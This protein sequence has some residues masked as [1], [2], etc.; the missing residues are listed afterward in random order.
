MAETVL[1]PDVAAEPSEP[2]GDLH[3][4]LS[5]LGEVHRDGAYTLRWA[6]RSYPL[7]RHT[8]ETLRQAALDGATPPT[9]LAR[10]VRRTPGVVGLLQVLGPPDANGF[11]TLAFIAIAAPGKSAFTI[12]DLAQALVFLNPSVTVLTPSTADTVLKHIAG[13]DDLPGMT[14]A[15]QTSQ[16]TW[17]VPKPLVDASGQPVR[18][19]DGTQ[20]HTYELDP[21]VENS[22]TPVSGQSTTAIYSDATLSGARWKL[23]PGVAHLDMA[24]PAVSGGLAAANGSGYRISLL[25]GGPNFGVSVTVNGLSDDF[26]LDLTVTNS[27]VRHL[28]VFVSFLE[29]DG[30]TAIV[31][32]DNIWTQLMKG[33]M[34]PIVQAWLNLFDTEV[35]E[36]L[37]KMLES[38]DNT[39]KFC[40]TVGAEGTFLGIPV[41]TTSKNFTFALPSDVP[42]GT[43]RLMV[44]SLGTS[45]GLD[46]DPTAAWLG[47]SMTALIDLVVPTYALLSTAGEE[48]DTLFE[49]IF[50]SVPFLGAT[51][52][53]VFTVAKDIFDDPANTG[54]DLKA[55]LTSFADS[56]VSKVLTSSDVAAALAVYFGAEE[57]EEAIPYVGWALK[58]LAMGAA[59]AQLGQTIGEVIASPR[60]IEFDLKVTMDAVITLRPDTS[61]G[62]GSEFPATATSVHLTAQ[63]S[64]NTTRTYQ[65]AFDPAKG[66][67]LRIDWHD[68]PVGGHVTFV[69]A[70]FSAEGW[71]V[72]KGQ[73]ATIVNE[74]TKGQ[75]ALIVDIAVQQ[76]LY[77]IDADTT[78]RHHQLLGYD[79]GYAW[80][81]TAVAPTDT[82]ESLGTGPSGHQLEALAGITLS[83]DLG[84]LGYS[85]EASGLDIPPVD[86]VE[87]ATE[88]YTMQNISFRQAI[89]D[90]SPTWP[91]AGYMTAPAGYAK[92][93]LLL[94]LRTATGGG[95]QLAGPGFFFLDPTGD[96]ETGFHLRQ[97]SPV[98]NVGVP[99]DDPA[100]RFDLAR[101]TSWGRFASLPTSLAIH[102][103][104]YVVGV[105]PAYDNLQIVELAATGMPDA[106]AP[107]AN[108]PLGPGTG[109]GR[110]GAPA[111]TCIRPD[112]T[113]LVLEARNQRVQAFSRG[114]HPAPRSLP[115][116]PRTGSRWSPMPRR[117]PAW[118][119]CRS[120][121]TSPAT[122]ISSARPATATTR[123]TSTSTSTPRPDSICCTSRDSWPP[124]STSISGGTSTR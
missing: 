77:P 87:T 105:D 92:A 104:G 38:H 109:P 27:Y 2:T 108:I 90:P 29:G 120:V 100:R 85:W 84:I 32:D 68:I 26:V 31:V 18:K 6:G 86:S 42:V 80:Q 55:A 74:I 70:M 76:K 98:I 5:F 46:W 115:A 28:S 30:R 123:W 22:A 106:Q 21:M 56:L 47:L 96:A 44:G 14:F 4:D 73:S 23:L 61:P 20:Y 99:V 50:E 95:D 121:S 107:W 114:G 13:T 79:N 124:A 25:D 116:R 43:V 15:I 54:S 57:V 112:Q 122:P 8:P 49:N 110:L 118:S 78:Y 83:D 72:G 16:S 89:G 65:E 64:D 53:S 3:V 103:N 1:S 117:E 91:Q 102:S 62:T 58:A 101:G 63:Y 12:T 37:R 67:S 97:V 11:A 34:L 48:S 81:E 59:A 41:S 69:V 66:Q 36:E 33:A 113:I 7:D 119:T 39:L 88:L 17:N 51:A 60:V 82:A 94:Y 40:G 45:S 111:L 52:V 35:G 9:H 93:P 75:K 71:G 10:D 19:P 24:D